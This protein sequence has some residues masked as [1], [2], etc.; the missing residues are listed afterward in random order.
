MQWISSEIKLKKRHCTRLNPK[1][2]SGAYYISGANTNNNRKYGDPDTV[3]TNHKG[4]EYFKTQ[5]N[6]S[7]RQTRWWEYL[8]CFNYNTIHVDG[9]WNQVADSLSCYYEYD[10]IED[11]HPNSEFVKVDELLD[12]DRDL[13]PVQWFIEIQNNGIRQSQRLQEKIPA[14]WL[15]SQMLNET[16]NKVPVEQEQGDNDTIAHTSDN[17]RKPLLM[18]IEKEFNLNKT[19]MK[20]YWQDKIYSKILENPKAHVR[21]GVRQGL[22]FTKNNLSRDVICISPKAIHKGKQVIEIIIDHAHNIIGH[23]GQFK[24]AQYI[25]RYFW[26]SSMLHNIELYCKTCSI[27]TTT[28]D[29]NSEPTGLLHSLLI[30]DRPWQSIGMDFM[31]P[32]PKLNNFNYLLVMIDQLTSQVHLLPTTI[33]VTTRGIAWLTLKEVMRLHGIP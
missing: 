33:M 21:F 19:I 16:F 27:C 13:A 3:V 1:P 5:P 30:L 25:K 4:L 8:S 10:T 18:V 20:F 31:G 32:L 2:D 15:E 7:P 6:L 23:Y 11:E 29:A 12:L 14:A 9:T 22:I 28:K 24:T 17:S 26:W